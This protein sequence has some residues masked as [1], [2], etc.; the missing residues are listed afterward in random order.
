MTR[1]PKSVRQA[2][3]RAFMQNIADSTVNMAWTDLWQLSHFADTPAKCRVLL[4]QNNPQVFGSSLTLQ[5]KMLGMHFLNVLDPEIIRALMSEVLGNATVSPI[6]RLTLLFAKQSMEVTNL[7]NGPVEIVHY[8]VRAKDNAIFWKASICNGYANWVGQSAPI[9]SSV[10]VN[11]TVIPLFLPGPTPNDKVMTQNLV[12]RFALAGAIAGPDTG[13]GFEVPVNQSLT[14]NTGIHTHF[15]V[16][17]IKTY[18]LNPGKKLRLSYSIKKPR[19]IPMWNYVSNAYAGAP[20]LQNFGIIRGHSMSF[21]V[22]RGTTAVSPGATEGYNVGLGNVN[23]AVAQR[24]IWKYLPLGTTTRREYGTFSSV[25][26]F[27]SSNTVSATGWATYPTENVPVTVT[28]TSGFPGVW[29][30]NAGM[31]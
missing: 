20:T 31:P 2:K 4:S 9:G 15:R 22:L 27:D 6:D 3:L 17:S 13:C 24:G 18:K 5:A 19:S 12:P 29:S 25:A 16:M 8:R 1:L 21:F 28:T 7:E 14:M 30:N 26:G 10:P 11:G 23:C